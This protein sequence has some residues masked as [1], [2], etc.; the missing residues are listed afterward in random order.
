MSEYE[1]LSNTL[2][3]VTNMFIPSIS[4]RTGRR[5]VINPRDWVVKSDDVFPQIGVIWFDISEE[6][7]YGDWTLLPFAKMLCL[8]AITLDRIC[9]I[10]SNLKG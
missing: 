3:L 10:V 5:N 1:E 6:V 4:K 7:E 8:L 2:L 9:I